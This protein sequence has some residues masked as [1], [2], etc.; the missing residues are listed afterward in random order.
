MKAI[1][2]AS[3]T[4]SRMMPYTKHLPKCMIKI[5]SK[6]IIDFEL[7]AL[8][9]CGIKEAIITTGPFHEFVVSELTSHYSG[10]HI[11]FIKN[12]YYSSTNYL[13]SLWLTRD[14]IHEP[15][16]LLHGDLLFDTELIINLT[17]SSYKNAVLVNKE[18]APP[19][20]D[21]KAL[22]LGNRVQKIGV[23]ILGANA[24][25]C[26]PV[27]KLSVKAFDQWLSE[28]DKFV[29]QDKMNFYAEDALNNILMQ[30]NLNAFFYD[31]EFCMEI[32]VPEDFN[33]AKTHLS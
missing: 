22:I 8:A 30:L 27:Y 20:K 5:G 13:Y 6:T 17:Q 31:D 29:K 10:I 28:I 11:D 25:F 33:K 23:G 24:F 1:I 15:L 14:L 18:I 21:F 9:A 26:A 2:L 19:E 4:G 16:I 7:E 3:G 32:D 12:Y